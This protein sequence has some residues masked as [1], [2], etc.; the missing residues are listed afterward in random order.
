M[1]NGW[2]TSAD[3]WIKDMGE[4]GDFSRRYV[5]DPVML[6]LALERSP[7]TALDVGCGEGR[8]C[9]MLGQHG[10]ETTGIDPTPA[11]IAAARLRDAQGQYLE[12]GAELLP[13]S[14]ATF[15]LVVSY[16]T[17]I[18]IADFGAA[19]SEMVRVLKPGGALLIANINSF[20]SACGDTGWIKDS[21]GRR[22]YYPIDHYLKERS[23]LIKYRGISIANYHRPLGAYMAAFL[24]AGMRLT[25][26]SEPSPSEDAPVEK[27]VNYRRVPWFLV[28]EWVKLAT[29]GQSV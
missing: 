19:I 16:L 26:F 27:A 5:L 18:D 28:M 6:R 10:V 20:N 4:N 29:P 11:L 14:D 9:R 25:H 15:D 17:L 13:F 1:D 23:M 2:Q 12:A 21:A 8:F 7:K 22:L 3:A 24:D